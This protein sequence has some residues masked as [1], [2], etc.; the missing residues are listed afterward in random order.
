LME[1]LCGVFT[2]DNNVVIS[3]FIGVGSN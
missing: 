1:H 2:R 3:F